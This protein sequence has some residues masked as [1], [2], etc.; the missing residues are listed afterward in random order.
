MNDLTWMMATW[1]T[2]GKRLRIG[3]EGDAIRAVI[4]ED[5]TAGQRTELLGHRADDTMSVWAHDGA[6]IVRVNEHGEPL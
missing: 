6:E 2:T 1:P 4:S 3:I 5:L